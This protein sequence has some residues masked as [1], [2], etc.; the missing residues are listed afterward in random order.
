MSW[1]EIGLLLD[2]LGFTIVFIFGGFSF[3]MDSLL[4]A[5]PSWF[6]LPAKIFGGTL[7]VTGFIFQFIGASS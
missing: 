4:L 1:T 7:V 3:G 5:A 6:V 2:A